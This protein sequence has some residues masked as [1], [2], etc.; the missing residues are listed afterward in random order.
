MLGERK[1]FLKKKKSQTLKCTPIKL[2]KWQE[3][4]LQMTSTQCSSSLRKI[5]ARKFFRDWVFSEVTPHS[6]YHQGKWGRQGQCPG[7]GA[8]FR[9][10]Q[11]KQHS[12]VS[13]I[14][15]NSS[16]RDYLTGPR[17]WLWKRHLIKR[18]GSFSHRA[19]DNPHRESEAGPLGRK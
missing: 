15:P 8:A 16:P 4:K 10:N 6:G 11:F 18:A 5:A 2:N 12:A 19:K 7:F 3:A 14:L 1:R 9:A 17:T 13:V